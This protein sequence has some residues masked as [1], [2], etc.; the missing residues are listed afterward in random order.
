MA[1]VATDSVATEMV[2]E[3]TAMAVRGRVAVATA[4][5]GVGWEATAMAVRGRATVVMAV[6]SVGREARHNPVRCIS[7]PKSPA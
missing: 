3:A 7:G 2:A 5:E 1:A 4:M 6:D